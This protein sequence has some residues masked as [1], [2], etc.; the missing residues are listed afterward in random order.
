MYKAE[1]NKPIGILDSGVGGLT[2]VVSMQRLLPNESIIYLGDSLRM[3]Y[4]NKKPDEIVNLA[5]N[6]ISFLQKHEVKAI[7]LACNT[8]SAHIE[9]LKSNLTLISII[10][11]GALAVK[12]LVQEPAVGL[13]ATHATVQ[14]G[15]YEKKIKQYNPSLKVISNSSTSLPKII[16]SQ[17]EN[18]SLLNENIKEIIDP[19]LKEDDQIRNL[20]LGC[21]HFP[22]IKKEINE[23]YPDIKLIDPAEKQVELLKIYLYENDLI[24]DGDSKL[25][26]F[27]T[28]ETYEYA[29]AI[30]R[31]YLEIDA[32]I[33]VV[34]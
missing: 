19:I 30:K 11:A 14:S 23:I 8:I 25:T 32:L 20:I 15:M 28:A 13:I 6:L 26:V 21:S 29:A 9:E 12:E 27:T 3:P 4:G 34:L 31:L 17:L 24:N 7:L 33:K 18:I 5:N 22:I 2:A 1:K 16:D 10:E